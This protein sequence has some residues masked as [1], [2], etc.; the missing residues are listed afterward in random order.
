[1]F[2]QHIPSSGGEKAFRPRRP[3]YIDGLFSMSPFHF[4]ISQA[5]QLCPDEGALQEDN[6]SSQKDSFPFLAFP[7]NVIKAESKPDSG[8]CFAFINQ[9]EIKQDRKKQI[10]T[11]CWGENK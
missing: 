9:E 1:M 6:S 2:P 3:A 4:E 5:H 7:S 10:Q 11:E 8:H